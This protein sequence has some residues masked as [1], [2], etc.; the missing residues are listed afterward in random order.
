M[1]PPLRF[2]SL[3]DR[4]PSSGNFHSIRSKC[5]AKTNNRSRASYAAPVEVRRTLRPDNNLANAEIPAVR[6]WRSV[7]DRYDRA[8]R[9]SEC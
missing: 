3:R 5:R 6:G 8:G 4:V 9:R 2:L 1:R 7:V